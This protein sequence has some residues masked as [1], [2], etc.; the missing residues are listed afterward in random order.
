MQQLPNAYRQRN[1]LRAE[2]AEIFLENFNKKLKY[3]V[4]YDDVRVVESIKKQDGTT[5]I[6]KAFGEKLEGYMREE[7][8]VLTGSPKVVQGSDIIT[9][10]Q[11]TLVENREVVEVDDSSSRL[12]IKEQYGNEE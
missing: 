6:R 9:A 3:Y 5:V 10:N 12:Q 11:I 8:V 1:Y 7:K 4:L 2:K